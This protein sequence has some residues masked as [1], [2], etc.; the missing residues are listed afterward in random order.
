MSHYY[1]LDNVSFDFKLATYLR[2]KIISDDSSPVKA[3]FDIHIQLSNDQYSH[4]S[5]EIDIDPKLRRVK[6]CFKSFKSNTT[7][8]DIIVLSLILLSSI[9]HIASFI[10]SFG[11][12]KVFH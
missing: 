3:E 9:T 12:A 10:R 1:R 7:I 5:I 11:L 8:T 2:D 6:D 4:M